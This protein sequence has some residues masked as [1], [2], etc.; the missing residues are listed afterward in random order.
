MSACERDGSLIL[1][2]V[3]SIPTPIGTKVFRM[4]EKS[5]DTVKSS[6]KSSKLGSNYSDE[7]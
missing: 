6:E 2:N 7:A 4:L 1:E 3:G 5:Y